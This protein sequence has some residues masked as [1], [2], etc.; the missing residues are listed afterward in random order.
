ML[1]D[2]RVEPT[3][4][5]GAHAPGVALEVVVQQVAE[6][7][8]ALPR[9]TKGLPP[10]VEIE[11]ALP[12]KV[13]MTSARP[14]SRR[15]SGRCR[16]P[17]RRCTGRGRPRGPGSP[18]SGRPCGPSPSGPRRSRGGCRARRATFSTRPKK[19]SGGVAKPPTPWMGSAM[20]Q[21]TSPLVVVSITS[22]RSSVQA[23]MKS[24]SDRSRNGRAEAVAG[25]Y[26]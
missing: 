24:A 19:P 4:D 5:A 1:V 6:V 11:F 9:R 16:G 25:L 13:F 7:G 8:R 14:T 18:R 22:R 10:N 15:S 23:P 26:M 12:D 2:E 21:A 20:R 17:W 3:A